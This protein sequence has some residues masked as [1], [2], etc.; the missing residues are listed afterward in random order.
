M[1][2]VNLSSNFLAKA[3]IINGGT[4]LKSMPERSQI[5]VLVAEGNTA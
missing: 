1:A 5:S 2:Q 3:Y 4:W